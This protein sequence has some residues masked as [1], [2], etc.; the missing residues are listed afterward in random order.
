[1]TN[2]NTPPDSPDVKLH[3]DFGDIE[4]ML[5]MRNWLENALEQAGAKSVGAGMGMGAA[6]V[7]IK[8]QGYLFN[9]QIRPIE[10]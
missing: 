6:D 1:M 5:N 2:D 4:T 10:G 8:L 9:V 3:A 7:Q